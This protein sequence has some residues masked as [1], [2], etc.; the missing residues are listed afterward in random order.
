MKA[1]E[2]AGVRDLATDVAEYTLPRFIVPPRSERDETQPQLFVVDNAPDISG[3]LIRHWGN[4]CA[5]IDATYL[6]EEYGRDRLVGWLP[7]MFERARRGGA[8]PIPMASLRDLG[9]QEAAAFRAALDSDDPLKLGIWVSSGEM[10]GPALLTTMRAALTRID[11]SPSECAIVADFYDADFSAPDLVSPII[12][13]ALESLQDLGPWRHVIF[14]GTHFPDKNP[15]DHGSRT[16]WPRNEWKAWREAVRFDPA[17]AEHMMFGDYAADCAKMVF[18]DGGGRAIRHFR[19]A[20]P[21]DWLVERG[22]ASGSDN[23]VM[24]RVCA[25]IV[26]SGL[27]AGAGF[28]SADAYILRTANNEDG[29]GNATTWRQ[30]NTTHHITRVV[31]DIAKVRGI[32]ITEKK[33]SPAAGQLSLLP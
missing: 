10:V 25:E 5:F 17:T 26:G 16:L 14:Q 20:T 13:G 1:G 3:A 19:Y 15:A 24:Q 7:Q 6:I 22:D 9:D 11:L 30:I 27:F 12:S 2:L 8:S 33:A 18:G 21:T 32:I 4:R 31:V 29:P 23:T 28:S